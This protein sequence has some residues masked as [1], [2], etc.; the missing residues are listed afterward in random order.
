MAQPP[1]GAP[2]W[3][4]EHRYPGFDM[5]VRVI[6]TIVLGVGW[7][8]FILLFAAFWAGGY[9]LFQDIVILI[10]SFLVLGGL[11]GAM[12]ASWGMRYARW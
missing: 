8:I 3:P 4:M 5:R 1:P 12:W 10:V 9:S 7:L 6:A 2:P 11:L